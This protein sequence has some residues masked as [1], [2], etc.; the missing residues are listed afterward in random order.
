MAG[1][2]GKNTIKGGSVELMC[3]LVVLKMI[4]W[5]ATL[6]LAVTGL[7]PGAGKDTGEG[8]AGKRFIVLQH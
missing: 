7:L 5:K 4:S 1:G 2:E 8:G 6:E 3:W